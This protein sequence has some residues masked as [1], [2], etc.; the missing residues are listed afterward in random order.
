METICKN[1]EH[2]IFCKSWG[3]YKCLHHA[4]KFTTGLVGCKNHKKQ[5]KDFKKRLCQCDSC[6][7]A[8]KENET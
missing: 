7:E 2:A 6:V 4:R 5:G 8:R 1:C 3:E